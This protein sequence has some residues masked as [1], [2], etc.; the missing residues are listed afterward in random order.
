MTTAGQTPCTVEVAVTKYMHPKVI[1]EVLSKLEW[2][3]AHL[4]RSR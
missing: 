2:P 1:R 4:L 3:T